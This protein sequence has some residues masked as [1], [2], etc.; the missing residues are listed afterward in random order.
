MLSNLNEYPPHHAY[1][2]P[3]SASLVA[4]GAYIYEQTEQQK[5]LQLAGKVSAGESREMSCSASFPGNSPVT[6][7]VDKSRINGDLLIF[8]FYF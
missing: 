7:G 3:A 6:V 2:L 5:E 8:K 1:P 4:D